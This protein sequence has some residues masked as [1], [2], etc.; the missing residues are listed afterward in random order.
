MDVLVAVGGTGVLVGVGDGPAVLV[1]V[2]VTGVLVAVGTGVLVAVSGTSVFVA[3]DGT[4]VLVGDD[5]DEL[6]TTSSGAWLPSREENDTPSELFVNST[7]LLAPLPV[8]KAETSYS[9][10]VSL[11]IAPTSSSNPLTIAG[12]VFQVT[13]VSVQALSTA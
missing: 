8:T 3:V 6:V 13:P 1:F 10:Q 9:I 7:K 2:G 4:G 5:P 12:L 11:D